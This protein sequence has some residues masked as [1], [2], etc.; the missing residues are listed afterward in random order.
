MFTKTSDGLDIYFDIRGNKEAKETIVLLNGLT[1]S[2]DAWILVLPYFEKEYRILLLDF[3][4]QGQ[5]EK[6]GEWRNFEQHAEDVTS[7]MKAVGINATHILGI[8]YGSLVAQ[9][10][11][12]KFP[13][14]VKSLILLSTFA[15]KTPYYEAIELAWWRSL[16][17]GGYN[18]MLDIMLPTVLSEE[19]F[20]NPLVSIKAM[21]ES[22]REK[23]QSADSILKLMRATKERGDFRKYLRGIRC[24]TLIIQGEKDMLLP[25]HMAVEVEKNIF[26]SKLEVIAHAGHTLNLEHV[27]EVCKKVRD[28]LNEIK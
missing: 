17:T 6:G 1:Q 16:E 4:F 2:S 26:G 23:D 9:H 28:F 22:R 19:Y 8:S 27:P 25:V 24:R 3:I 20:L 18:L 10:F 7:V 11:A 13:Q 12:L 15:H 14:L 21:K 5:S